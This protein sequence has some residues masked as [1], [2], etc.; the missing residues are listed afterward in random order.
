MLDRFSPV[1]SKHTQGAV[2]REYG[3][4]ISSGCE[5]SHPD[6]E[7]Q[8]EWRD[9]RERL[10]PTAL[11]ILRQSKGELSRFEHRLGQQLEQRMQSLANA[12]QVMQDNVQRSLAPLFE[13]FGKI[14]NPCK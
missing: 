10:N 5:G 6:V 3:K 14:S 7:Q 4:E 11:Q 13:S 8:E 12:M 1:T 2:R 9:K